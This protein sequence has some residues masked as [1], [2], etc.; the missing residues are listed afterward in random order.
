[1]KRTEYKYT[2]ENII[3]E[4][5]KDDLSLCRLE[6]EKN[7]IS[8]SLSCIA[9]IEPRVLRAECMYKSFIEVKSIDRF[10]VHCRL[11][12]W[13]SSEESARTSLVLFS[14]SKVYG[15]SSEAA[16]QELAKLR[17]AMRFAILSD[18]DEPNDV[19][20]AMQAGA[21]GY[22]STDLSFEVMVQIL[23]LLEAG[24]TYAPASRFLN[25][26]ADPKSNEFSG[27]TDSVF[28]SHRQMLVARA[29][30]KGAPNKIIAYQLGMCE[31]TVKVHVRNIMKK[32]NVRNRT[33]VALWATQRFADA[34]NG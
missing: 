18:T 15:S 1:M 27:K 12:D 28:A 25:L 16:S 34:E 13:A 29:M 21:Q 4:N 7:N 20:A 23:L 11:S 22:L 19:R 5:E 9:L 30:C 6:E 24:G 8:K 26:Y 32:L 14:L 10:S 33:E 17:P 2:K 3:R 31:S